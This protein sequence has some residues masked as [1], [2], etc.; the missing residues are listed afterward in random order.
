MQG[1]L[2]ESRSTSCG[3]NFVRTSIKLL[4][5]IFGYWDFDQRS[6]DPINAF[7]EEAQITNQNCRIQRVPSSSRLS[8]GLARDKP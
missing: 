8:A 4:C 6:C 1:E 5:V 7:E 3:F 2:H